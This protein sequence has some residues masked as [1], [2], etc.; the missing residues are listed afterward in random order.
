MVVFLVLINQAE[1]AIAVRL[2]FFNR[3]WFDAIQNR[4][5]AVFWQ[6]LLLVSTIDVDDLELPLPDSA[7][8]VEVDDLELKA[9]ERIRAGPVAAPVERRAAAPGA[10]ARS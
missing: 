4:S 10:R 5:E 1:V 7:R 3:A 2:K 8:I 9:H 6:Q